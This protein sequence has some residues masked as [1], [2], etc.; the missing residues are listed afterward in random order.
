MVDDSNHRKI[1]KLIKKYKFLFLILFL[2]VTPLPIISYFQNIQNINF[3][4]DSVKKD[5]VLTKSIISEIDVSLTNI[6]YIRNIKTKLPIILKRTIS[7]EEE[8]NN[9]INLIDVISQ[10]PNQE[11]RFIRLL[12]KPF[13]TNIILRFLKSIVVIETNQLSNLSPTTN[14]IAIYNGNKYYPK[15]IIPFPIETDEELRKAFEIVF[16]RSIVNQVKEEIISIFF[17]ALSPNATFEKEFQQLELE[18]HNS[19]QNKTIEVIIKKG[20]PI[21]REGTIITEEHIQIL[22]EYL[23]ELR[24]KL[25]L[26]TILTEI[27]VLIIAIFSIILLSILKEVKNVNIMSINALVLMVS[28]YLQLY[29]KDWLGYITIFTSLLV[30]FSLINSLISG[31]KTT[32]VIGIYYSLIVLLTLYKS[33]LIIIYWSILTIVGFVMSHKIK[34]RSSFIFIAVVIFSLNFLLYLVINFIENFEIGNIPIA[35]L[36]SFASV[37]GNVLLVFLVLPVYEYFFRI[38]TP[39]KL[40]ELSSLDNELLKM[41]REKAPGTYYHSLNVSILAEAAAEAINANSLLAKVGALYHDIGKIEKP[42]YFTENIGGKTREDV[43]IYEYAQII[44]Q[45][46][47]IGTEIARKYNLPIEIELIIKEHHGGSVIYYFYNKALKENPNVDINL[48]KYEN[49][50]PTFKESGIVYLCD[51]LE[52]KIRSL[53]SNQSVN[54]QTIQEVI[55]DSIQQEVLKEELSKSDLTLQDVNNIKKAIKDTFR[56]I[57]HQRI[58]YPK[59]T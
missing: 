45:H 44:K 9:I 8:A 42:D 31:R 43:N 29:L 4:I 12:P 27:L 53:A 40:Y 57:L 19:S 54:I 20:S 28:V 30:W 7:P 15:K 1:S 47:K 3:L 25:L 14:I 33:Y 16:G 32:L 2:P 56:Y 21:I 51:K 10:E 48:F 46:P 37:F 55:D 34:R 38:A 52:A 59:S 17:H 41:L 36:I 18:K 24:S 50:K 13:L 23:E 35:S 39:F 49:Y 26:S 5:S 6:L 22:K 11:I 58:E